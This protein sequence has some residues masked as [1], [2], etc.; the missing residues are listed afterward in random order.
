[1]PLPSSPISLFVSPYCVTNHSPCC[2]SSPFPIM[3]LHLFF[4]SSLPPTF[5][6]T[7]YCPVKNLVCCAS[8][9]VSFIFPLSPPPSVFKP[10]PFFLVCVLP[11]FYHSSVSLSLLL[12]PLITLPSVLPSGAV[13]NQVPSPCSPP[14]I[15]AAAYAAYAGRGYASYPGFGF[16]YPTGNSSTGV[17][18]LCLSHPVDVGLFNMHALQL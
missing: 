10:P 3:C 13:Y 9:F 6:P 4:C 15:Q 11:A 2:P 8:S 17:T 7:V 5:L 14:G 12:S 16:P 1:M 18:A